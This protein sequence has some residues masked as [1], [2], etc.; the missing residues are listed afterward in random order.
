MMRFEDDSYFEDYTKIARRALVISAS[1]AI[2]LQLVWVAMPTQKELAAIW[3]APRMLSSENVDKLTRVGE[4]GNDIMKL[5][6]EYMKE[7]LKEKGK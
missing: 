1:F 7:T 4:N 3:V 6:T 5:A 2:P